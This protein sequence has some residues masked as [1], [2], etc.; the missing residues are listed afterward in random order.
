[1]ANS[2]IYPSLKDRVVLVTGGAMGIGEAIVRAFAAQGSRIGF[3]DIADAAAKK[4]QAELGAQAKLHY[5]HCDV[6][7]I[8]ALQTAIGKVRTALGPITVLVNNAAHDERHT[9]ADVTPELFD[10]RIAVNLKHQFFAAQA[11]YPDMK[12]AQNGSIV[13]FG[14]SSWMVG[15]LNLSIYATAK[16][17]VLGLTRSLAREFGPDNIRVNCVVP[18]WI[19]TE[20]QIERW[21]TPEG[22]A[23]LMKAQ[24]IKRK[25]YPDDV[26]RLVMFL[27]SDDSSGCT[28]QSHVIDG[29][30]S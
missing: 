2:A 14:S 6:T 28:N 19:M 20:R 8:A 26:A 12:A 27:A 10:D 16:A 4:L 1:M 3:L 15:D 25:L 7:D 13:N 17:G 9:V 21:L 22:E 29:G 11:V 23:N 30:R 5:E 18:G 24:C